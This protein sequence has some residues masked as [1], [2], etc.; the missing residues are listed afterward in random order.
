MAPCLRKTSISISNS[1]STSSSTST[2]SPTHNN[3]HRSHKGCWTC[4]RKRIH[5]DE[6]HPGCQNCTSKGVVCEGYEIRLRWGSGIASRGRYNGAAKPSVECIPPPSKRRW[7]LRN[8]SRRRSDDMG[9]SVVTTGAAGG[10]GDG[11]E[12]DEQG[13]P[14]LLVLGSGLNGEIGGGTRTELHSTNPPPP[15]TNQVPATVNILNEPPQGDHFPSDYLNITKHF[16]LPVSTRILE[17][18]PSSPTHHLLSPSMRHGYQTSRS[19]SMNGRRSVF[20]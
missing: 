10:G 4:K 18:Q 3:R 9:E 1:S 20:A 6:T 14:V 7:D 5:C 17:P 15:A 13:Q 11:S 19:S 8:K 2:T 16:Q 12:G